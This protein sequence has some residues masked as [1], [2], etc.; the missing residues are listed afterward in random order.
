MCA[1]ACARACE[2]S[3]VSACVSAYVC[4]FFLIFYFIAVRY[5]EEHERTKTKTL[6]EKKSTA[7]LKM[8]IRVEIDEIG[9]S[10]SSA[11]RDTEYVLSP[12]PINI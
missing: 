11:R 9:L 8:Q 4:N 1:C 10:C 2:R 12:G 3:C 5:D 7:L 6:Q